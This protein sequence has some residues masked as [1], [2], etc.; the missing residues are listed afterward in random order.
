MPALAP[1]RKAF[2]GII[3][4]FFGL[5]FLVYAWGLSNPFVRW[6]DGMLIYE[7]PVIRELT[8]RS[9]ARVFSMYDP[10]LYIPLT[11]LTYQIDYQIAGIH[12]FLYHL[13]NLVL[14]TL[15]AL[16]AAWFLFL[17]TKNRAAALFAGIVFAVHPLHTEAVEWASARKDVL[18]TCF[19]L[20]S[21]I[22]YLRYREDIGRRPYLWSVVFFVLGLLSKVMVITLPAVLLLIDWRAGRKFGRAMLT[23]KIPYAVAA[24]VFGIIAIFGKTAVVASS[25][26]T[27][28]ILMA[29]KS[30]VFYLKSIFWPAKLSLLYPHVGPISLREPEF[31]LYAAIVLA[32]I[33]GAILLH[34]RWKDFSFAVAFYLLTLA[35]TFINFAKGGEM[36]LYFASDRYAYVPSIGIFFLAASV[37]WNARV[38]EY[39]ALKKVMAAA[40]GVIIAALSF[41]SYRQSL[42]WADTESLFANVIRHY[43]ASSHVAHNNL[44]NARRLDGDLDGAIEE[45]E[46]ALAIR[47]HAKTMSNL[48]GAY[49]LQ[50]RMAEAEG[51]YQQALLTDPRSPVAHF[52]HGLL[53]EQQGK[54]G[55]A[56]QKYRMAMELDPKSEEAPTNLASLLLRLGR[57]DEAIA[58]Y[59]KAL[60][61]N[62]YYPD[63]H[64]NLGVALKGLG[65]ADDAIEHYEQAV[66]LRPDFT[67]ARINLGLLYHGAGRGDEAAR[68]FQMILRYDPANKTARS[69]LEQMGLL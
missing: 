18:S 9:V 3:A 13:D 34:R 35:P 60:D 46:K 47:A 37:L 21:L 43:P 33:A 66:A 8:P 69:A 50:G 44:G 55:E 57:T 24:V 58:M 48:A 2:F 39:P 61:I 42:V 25:T 4:A 15:N 52:G 45:Y 49:R 40:C 22:A 51:M 5:T 19:F 27:A 67:A 23:D 17:L 36:D 7:N 6:D 41:L 29:C 64:F 38:Q 65:R 62:P 26:L 32:L 16:L 10:E 63:A 68:Q 14:H 56:E 12:P 53:L 20:A 54:L 1:S 30:T 28:K 31:M 11:F 59:E